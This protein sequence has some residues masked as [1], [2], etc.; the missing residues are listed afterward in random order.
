MKGTP[1]LVEEIAEIGQSPEGRN[2]ITLTETEDR[3]VEHVRQIALQ[4]FEQYHIDPAQYEIRNDAFGNM[5]ITLF[6]EDKSHTVMSGSHVDS[7]KNGGKYDGVAGVASALHF[8]ERLLQEKQQPHLSYTVAVFRAEESSPTTGVACLGSKIAT[9]TITRDAL[10]KIRYK[11][12]D[13]QETTL[14]EHFVRRYGADRWEQV[15]KELDEPPINRDNTTHFEEVHIEQS[16][17]GEM[18]EA[19]VGI[20]SEGIGGARREKVRVPVEKLKKE[21]LVVSESTPYVRVKITTHGRAEHSGGTPPNTVWITS[22]SGSG[23]GPR[24]DGRMITRSDALVALSNMVGNV[25]RYRQQVENPQQYPL[26]M[27][28]QIEEYN[29]KAEQ[30]GFP[31][32]AH[33]ARVSVPMETGYTTIPA[34]QTM[35]VLLPQ[36]NVEAFRQLVQQHSEVMAREGVSFDITT[37]PI[38]PGTYAVI[39]AEHAFAAVGIAGAVANEVEMHIL[40]RWVVNPTKVSTVGEIRATVTDFSLDPQKGLSFNIDERNVDTAQGRKISEKIASLVDGNLTFMEID[41]K[42]SRTVIS[43]TP[44]FPID[45]QSVAAKQHIAQTL[46]FK[47]IVMP[48]VPGHDA[49][50]IS[51][52]GIPTSMTYIRHPGISHSPDESV[53]P[54]YLEKA[55]AVSHEYLAQ[56]LNLR[57][58]A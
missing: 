42:K 25:E 52:T 11:E 53:D 45:K 20:V 47:T 27:Q 38:D 41:P 36:Q 50:S 1:E 34:E 10:E 7:V 48:S 49:G 12:T 57:A 17:L 5:F 16:R 33:I 14:K 18:M 9:G 40:G 21:E 6:G 24:G 56:L 51:K 3:T 58:A 39:P 54:Q 30:S 13:G 35:E 23:L 26:H 32:Y 15:L 31:R 2:T 4:L 28:A 19:D 55:V 22:K 8:L 46:G 44:P 37:E 43:D 29:R